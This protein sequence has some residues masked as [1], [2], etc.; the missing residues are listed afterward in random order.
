MSTSAHD[1]TIKL[2]TAAPA[3]ESFICM[4]CALHS[5]CKAAHSYSTMNIWNHMVSTYRS[6]TPSVPVMLFPPR[7]ST[8]STPAGALRRS[9]TLPTALAH[10]SPVAGEVHRTGL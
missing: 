4:L 3:F 1:L 2:L 6:Q 5:A 10:S 8:D 9:Q 7:Y